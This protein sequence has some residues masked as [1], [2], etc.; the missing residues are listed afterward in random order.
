MTVRAFSPAEFVFSYTPSD[1]QKTREDRA[2]A[3][4]DAC[5]DDTE[6]AL[7]SS[8]F[9][10]SKDSL[11]SVS[12]KLGTALKSVDSLGT[13]SNDSLVSKSSCGKLG[14]IKGFTTMRLHAT[15]F[16]PRLLCE[17]P[18]RD[19]GVFHI[20][21]DIPSTE[22]C[23]HERTSFV[24]TLTLK[25][26]HPQEIQFNLTASPGFV[27]EHIQFQVE[28]KA[29]NGFGLCLPAGKVLSISVRFDAK[30]VISRWTRQVSIATAGSFENDFNHDVVSCSRG[31]IEIVFDNG[32]QQEICLTVSIRSDASYQ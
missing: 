2:I 32:H 21:F 12:N 24:K 6:R 27:L 28:R 14:K 5:F 23:C 30:D 20:E 18:A 3:T 15:T 7:A 9:T 4:A 16:V 13:N 8:G 31:S 25:N 29:Q 11:S 17:Y 10:V 26:P 19:D 22:L 1:E